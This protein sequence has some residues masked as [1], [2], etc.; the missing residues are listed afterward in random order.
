MKN[1]TPQCIII[2]GPNGAGKTTCA[3]QFLAQEVDIIRPFQ[4]RSATR[5]KK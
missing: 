3:K 2:A 4:P 5:E 1:E